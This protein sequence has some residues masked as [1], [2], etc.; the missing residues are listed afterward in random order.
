[1]LFLRYDDL[2]LSQYTI[3]ELQSSQCVIDD[4]Q[5][6]QCAIDD[7]ESSQCFIDEPQSS[8]ITILYLCIS[9][10]NNMSTTLYFNQNL[11]AH[12]YCMIY[13]VPSMATFIIF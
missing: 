6:S 12:T 5:S 3:D 10:T 2:Q 7:L 8:E 11:F 4:L 1:M 9:K 13:F